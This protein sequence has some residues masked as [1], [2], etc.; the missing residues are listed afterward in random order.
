MTNGVRPIDRARAS[1]MIVAQV[2]GD[3]EMFA[4]A[5]QA[6]FDDDYGL[7]SMGATI[8]ALRVLTEDLAGV[9]IDAHGDRAADAVRRLLA[10]QLAEVDL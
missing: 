3:T 10:Q 5:V 2:T 7:G 4:A 6:M 8:N 1:Q 9:L